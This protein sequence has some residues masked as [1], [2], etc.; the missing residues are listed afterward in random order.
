[1]SFRYENIPDPQTRLDRYVEN[2]H[3][4]ILSPETVGFLFG[5]NNRSATEEILRWKD[6]HSGSYFELDPAKPEVIRISLTDHETDVHN[7]IVH[8]KNN[9]RNKHGKK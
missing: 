4:D 7:K 8:N 5:F 3:I 1:M 2:M 9:R 6:R